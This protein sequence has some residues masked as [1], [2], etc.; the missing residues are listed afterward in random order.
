MQFEDEIIKQI[1]LP[2]SNRLKYAALLPSSNEIGR[3][4][5]AFSN[6]Q[7]GIFLMGIL[8]KNNQ[9]SVIGLS[10]DFQ[11][12]LV[13]KNT[14]A[15]LS[16]I[17]QIEYG[18]FHHQG[19]KLFAIKV[20]KSSQII[21]FKQLQYEIKLMKIQSLDSFAQ[22]NP[23]TN[24]LD[25]SNQSML[26]LIL[27][28]LVDNP[29]LINVN[30]HTVRTTIFNNQISLSDAEELIEEIRK[31]GVVKIYGGK[32]IGVS[33]KTKPF[34]DNGGFLEPLAVTTLPIKKNIF[35]SYNWNHKQTANKLY[36]FLKDNGY[37]P[38]MDGHD[39]GYKDLISTFM[40]SIRASDYAILIISDEYLKSA[41]CMTE[42][43]HVLNDRNRNDK[44][45]P[46][47]HED[48]KIFKT[49][50]RMKYVEY[51]KL[52][53]DELQS[54][55]NDTDMTSAIE[56]IKKLKTA[57]RI[58]QDI[59]DFMSEISDMITSTIEEQEKTAY[60]SIIEYM[61]R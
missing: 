4:I 31:S 60:K 44:I 32:Y 46:I 24:I 22:H 47:R 45:L 15:K 50:D 20:K 51:W 38:S 7:G 16:P 2:E 42:V 13:L 58:H 25:M 57:K 54:I 43:L 11:V 23:N 5:S 48:V 53:V 27:K 9:F 30:K 29:G 19:K 1:G 12:N 26:N 37:T 35:I 28:Y 17:P 34:I 36:E 33:I 18:F 3:I 6:T 39:L 49:V 40:E 55:L 59:G 21:S 10:D 61:E 52:Q 41:N 56:E 14:I 8:S